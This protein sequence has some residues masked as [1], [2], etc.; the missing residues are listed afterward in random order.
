MTPTPLG[1]THPLKLIHFLVGGDLD[2]EYEV[3]AKGC[4]LVIFGDKIDPGPYQG[5]PHLG[6]NFDENEKEKNY[7]NNNILI[8]DLSLEEPC[9]CLLE[10]KNLW[11]ERIL[12]IFG[13]EGGGPSHPPS[14]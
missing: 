1:C 11:C 4:K 7:K 9:T 10:D 12:S 3:P 8:Q 6:K 14:L 2:L 13:T 5:E